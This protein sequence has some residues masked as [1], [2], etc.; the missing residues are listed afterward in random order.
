MRY[1]TMTFAITA[2]L[3]VS[4]LAG[5]YLP[6][7]DITNVFGDSA[8]RN[9][10]PESSRVLC[11]TAVNDALGAAIEAGHDRFDRD[12]LAA[13]FSAMLQV[14]APYL[15]DPHGPVLSPSMLR[16]RETDLKLPLS[17]GGDCDMGYNRIQYQLR[18]K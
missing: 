3:A 6:P 5:Q 10:V 4:C 2:A 8:R 17:S 14:C 15:K 16:Q 1:R 9:G 18:N 12:T 13:S 7:D 11:E